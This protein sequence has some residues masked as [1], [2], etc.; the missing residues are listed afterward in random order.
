MFGDSP[1]GLQVTTDHVSR[2]SGLADWSPA[3]GGM[4]LLDVLCL[5]ATL[6]R[7]DTAGCATLVNKI[8]KSI[9]AGGRPTKDDMAELTAAALF[10]EWATQVRCIPTQV[11]PTPDFEC[12][13]S[14]GQIE[15]E[16]TNSAAKQEQTARQNSAYEL[17]KRL[18]T[19]PSGNGFRVRF[20]DQLSDAEMNSLCRC[21]STLVRGSAGEVIDRWY[22]EAVA[23]DAPPI[24]PLQVPAWWQPEFA[25]PAMMQTEVVVAAGGVPAI[26]VSRNLDIQWMLSTASYVNSLSKK[27]T[28]HQA[29]GVSPFVVAC[30]V[31]QLLGAFKWYEA[32]LMPYLL[33]WSPAISAVILITQGIEHL[34]TLRWEYRLFTNPNATLLLSSV[35]H[36][37]N[38]GSVIVPFYAV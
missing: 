14:G 4:H 17:A 36:I 29:S 31:T 35:V 6:S 8:A 33:Q 21:A 28:A 11:K 37:P 22:V 25:T 5:G 19:V 32:N 38:S 13:V 26:V 24:P 16:V 2:L 10:S 12:S 27:S 20:V 1:P 3:D 7:V 30:N 9:L 34:D 15:L 18:R 23:P